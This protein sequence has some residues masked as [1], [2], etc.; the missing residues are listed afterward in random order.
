MAGI[1]KM[2]REI[3]KKGRAED[4][5]AEGKVLNR[6]VNDFFAAYLA[7]MNLE[8]NELV[9]LMREHFTDP[10]MAAMR[11]AIMAGMPPDRFAVIL[12]WMLPSL[13]LDELTGML[14]GIRATAP[15]PVV[16]FIGG[17]AAAHL[18]PERW[19]T[20]RARVDW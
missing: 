4:R 3:P 12:R 1:A 19:Q 10:Q 11:S 2:A 6:E 8:E 7:H 18:P 13:T 20:V 5:I 15:P 9:P 16:T 14:K 17:V